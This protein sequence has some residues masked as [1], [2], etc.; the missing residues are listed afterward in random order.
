[1]VENSHSED[2]SEDYA[3]EHTTN[4]ASEQAAEQ[5]Y[6]DTAE[7]ASGSTANHASERN[8]K[9]VKQT[10]EEEAVRT[11]LQSMWGGRSKMTRTMEKGA[12]GEMFVMRELM[13]K[14]T[15]TPSQLANAMGVTSGR[16]STV[17]SS[18]LKK[19]LI[20]RTEDPEDRRIARIELSDQGRA[21]IEERNQRMRADLQWVFKQM[22]ERRTREFVDLVGE[23][24]TYMRLL[25]P[26]SDERPTQEQIR[27][28]FEEH[29]QNRAQVL[30]QSSAEQSSRE[31]AVRKN[32]HIA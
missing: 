2:S 22:G 10:P 24:T 12:H 18:L 9:A 1:M 30:G 23:F 29:D 8:A 13:T 20:L 28:A 27:A 26:D 16:V 14:G 4:H 31:D 19:G 21:M 7:Y 11:L 25:K 17:I 32:E 5:S 6:E 3:S 15:C